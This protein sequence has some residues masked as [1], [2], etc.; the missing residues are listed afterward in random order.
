MAARIL[1]GAEIAEQIKA[2]VAAEVRLLAAQGVRPGLA[3]VLVGDD[4]ASAIYVRSKI[5]ACD[6]LGIYGE[7]VTLPASVS[8]QELLERVAG[9]NRRDDIDAILV[10]LPLPAHIDKH[11]VLSDI[12][13]EKDV[14]GLHPV[15]AGLLSQRRDS[16]VPCTPA[17]VMELLRHNG[18]ATAG[19]EAVV[20]GRSNIVGKP[21]AMLLTNADATVTL[22]HSQTRD[23]AAV[24]RR[25]DILVVAVGKPGL[26]TREHVK[27]G[28]TVVDIGIN[29]LE[30]KELVERFFPG[31][32]KRQINFAKN[33][34]VLVGDVCPE[35][36][37]IAGAL[38]P[39][40][41]GVGPLTIAMLMV[42][43][44]KAAR[45]RR[46]SHHAPALAQRG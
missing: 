33:G 10:Q 1:N 27:P 25:A 17:G 40:P 20:V 38:T 32:A 16:L 28:A 11:V 12:A 34:Y 42:N 21:M 15:N 9:L 5:K 30:S 31:D 14:D 4:P 46:A 22:C 6:A 35:V 18:I 36:A 2:G 41:G 19:V 3:A 45:L 8:A 44:L 37:E 29:R 39:V 7:G 13:P 23:L 26:I 43:T 24:T